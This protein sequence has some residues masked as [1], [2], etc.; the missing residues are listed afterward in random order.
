MILFSTIVLLFIF[1]F[2][3]ILFQFNF[4][5]YKIMCNNFKFRNKLGSK[6]TQL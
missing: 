4:Y 5:I 2:Y 6:S 3:F 1:I